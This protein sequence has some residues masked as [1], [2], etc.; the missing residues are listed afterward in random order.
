VM[1][2]NGVIADPVEPAPDASAQDRLLNA[3]GRPTRP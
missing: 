2:Q 3:L 1:R